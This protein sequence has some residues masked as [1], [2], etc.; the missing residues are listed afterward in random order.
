MARLRRAHLV[1]APRTF[2][3][4]VHAGRSPGFFA[5]VTSAQ[6]L[7][8]VTGILLFAFLGSIQ[9]LYGPLLPG[10]QRAFAIDTSQVGV[11]FTA[12]G[13]GALMGIF[14][15]SL[16]KA[17]IANRRW[18]TVATGLLLLGA[19]ALAMAPTWN[20]TLAAAF[21]LAIGFGIHVIRL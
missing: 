18:L 17:P 7:L 12:H 11:I 21:V 10:L 16:V 8:A 2:P 5:H 6:R 1:A 3:A 9:A 14:V 4:Y 20:T 13:L 15:P 19:A